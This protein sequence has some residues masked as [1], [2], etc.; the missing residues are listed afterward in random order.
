ML[1]IPMADNKILLVEDESIEAIDIK[2]TVESFFY[3][4]SIWEETVDKA[5]QICPILF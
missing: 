4:A 1:V 2:R 5:I 3:V